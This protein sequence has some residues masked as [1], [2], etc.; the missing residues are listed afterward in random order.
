MDG[1]R[2]RRW[3]AATDQANENEYE[4][5]ARTQKTKA[6]LHYLQRKATLEHFNARSQNRDLGTRC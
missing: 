2:Q 6:H 1:L 5:S 3:N 4:S